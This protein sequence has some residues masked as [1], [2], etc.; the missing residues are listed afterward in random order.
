MRRTPP[1]GAG[2]RPRRGRN[3]R[4][5]TA[6]RDSAHYI[7]NTISSVETNVSNTGDHATTVGASG[8]GNGATTDR[9]RT[10]T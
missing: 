7:Q 8:R 9:R 5:A 10:P 1:W 4:K 3:Q 2:E 6:R